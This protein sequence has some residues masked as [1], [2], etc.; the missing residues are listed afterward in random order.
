MPPIA[1]IT[2]FALASQAA[3]TSRNCGAAR[4][5]GVPNSRMSAPPEN[6]LPAP[7]STIARTASSAAARSSASSNAERTACEML[8]TGGFE[9]VM[10]AAAP[11]RA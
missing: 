1:A 4:A 11:S 6:R 7:A 9:N 5:A 8:F 2:G 3:M 10:T